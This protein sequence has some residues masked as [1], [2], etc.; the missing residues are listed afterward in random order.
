MRTM[1][2]LYAIALSAAL[3]IGVPA[4]A[5]T[6][7][8]GLVSAQG[9]FQVNSSA[10]SGNATLFDGSTVE[11]NAVP[12]DLKLSNGAQ[13]RLAT[14]SR[15]KVFQGRIV[16]E[17]GAGQLESAAAVPVEAGSLRIQSAGPDTVARVQ[18][19]AANK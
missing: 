10:V 12:S 9:T 2:S 18:L 14:D 13:L 19:V 17:K 4:S 3:A 5:A 6:S 7:G 11:T 16:L 8:I 1:R 15:A